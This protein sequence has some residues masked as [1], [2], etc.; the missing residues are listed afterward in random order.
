MFR[1]SLKSILPPSDEK[2]KEMWRK[3]SKKKKKVERWKNYIFLLQSVFYFCFLI[4]SDQT[5]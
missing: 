4:V 3:Y 5:V 2:V 1:F